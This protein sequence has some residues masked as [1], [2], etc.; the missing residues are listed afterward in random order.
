MNCLVYPQSGICTVITIFFYTCIWIP[1]LEIKKVVHM[2]IA[3][4]FCASHADVAYQEE[5]MCWADLPASR[6][7]DLDL[8]SKS[9]SKSKSNSKSKKRVDDDDEEE[10]MCSVCLMEFEREDMV[11]QLPRC[12]H[13]FHMGCIESWLHRNNFTCPLCRSLFL[14]R[15]TQDDN[16][17]PCKMHPSL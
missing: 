15:S 5:G 8:S 13:I 16:A 9:K 10:E 1:F 17:L 7:E 6:F 4:V 3:I 12:G 14:L 11:S 2:I